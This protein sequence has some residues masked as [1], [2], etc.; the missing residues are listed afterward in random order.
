[1]KKDKLKIGVLIDNFEISSWAFTMLKQISESNYAE[2]VFVA[3]N[4]S[5]PA[6]NNNI[7]SK[8]KSN[9]SRIIQIFIRKILQKIYTRLIER[10]TYLPDSLKKVSCIN[11]IGNI[12]VLNISPEKKQHSDYFID[13][14]ID[15]IK[16]YKPDILIRCGFRILRGKILTA[17]KYGIWSYHHGDNTMFRG[18]PPAFWESMENYPVT[19]TTLQILTE[20]LDNGPVLYKSFSSTDTMS[21]TDNKNNIYIK[22]ISFMTRKIKEL[23]TTG[24]DVFFSKLFEANI[25]PVFYSEKFYKEPSNRKLFHLIIKKLIQKYK[26][27]LNRLFFIEQWILLFDLNNDISTSL[28]RY[29]KI[30]PPKTL[31]WA[32]PFVLYKDD[33]YYIFIEEYE[34]KSK[35]GHI[36]MITMDHNG[37]YTLPVVILTK[38]YH[39]S[40]PFI[41][42]HEE[43]YYM[44]PESAN[45]ETIELYKC[46]DFPLKWEFQMNLMEGVRALDTTLLL[47]ENK[48]WMFTNIAENI[49]SSAWDE[50]YL[51][52]S[53]ELM[54]SN[55]KPHPLNP[56]ISDCR[57]SRPAGAIF[58]YND[59]LYRPS[60]NSSV[61]YGYGFNI[62][63]VDTI[64]EEI[65]NE[66]LVS[67]IAPNW[68]NNIL[69]THTYNKSGHLNIIDALY[70][71]PRFNHTYKLIKVVI[72]LCITTFIYLILVKG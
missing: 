65:Y 19:G 30:I 29:K 23:Y 39:L 64:T 40:Y 63:K 57:K 28:W 71:R 31:E 27:T 37:N 7:I 70:K 17:A 62:N 45:N 14:D 67:L 41:F 56:I 22:S 60:Q 24:E 1:M 6:I 58:S 3:K 38:P 54:C 4:N 13:S 26:L 11:I 8:I 2:I 68:N 25:H 36:S 59:T 5:K 47:Y 18:G 12:P 51:F 46:V 55:W 53:S 44:I 34:N 16:K 20:D 42:N 21:I 49:G 35:K 52:S 72:L 32:D 10:N 9:K 69:A 33:Y 15:K 48:W 50:L 43:C 61:R 66:T